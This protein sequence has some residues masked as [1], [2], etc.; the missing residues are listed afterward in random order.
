MNFQNT[1]FLN[2]SRQ[3]LLQDYESC[4]PISPIDIGPSYSF[5]TEQKMNENEVL[6]QEKVCT[7]NK[8]APLLRKKITDVVSNH[9]KEI[10]EVIDISCKQRWFDIIET[11]MNKHPKLIANSVD[12]ILTSSLETG[13]L[14]IALRVIKETDRK[15]YQKQTHLY[16]HLVVACEKGYS[17]FVE[18]C[19]GQP[20]LEPTSDGNQNCLLE[21]AVRNRNPATVKAVLENDK[22]DCKSDFNVLGAPIN[23]IL[24]AASVKLPI[25]EES[26]LEGNRIEIMQALYSHKKIRA[27][28][29]ANKDLKQI[30]KTTLK[31]DEK[32]S[33]FR[34]FFSKFVLCK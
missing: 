15:N 6:T 21:I 8:V 10:D 26:S 16:K 29:H 20:M 1:S 3:A 34:S 32:V 11:I 9:Q 18:V 28:I 14:K 12:K 24:L 19:K 31:I 7:I 25:E 5:N 2:D 4:N 33:G 22:V 27:R 30:Y 17:E 23:V 13:K